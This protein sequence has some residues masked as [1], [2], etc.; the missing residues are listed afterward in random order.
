MKSIALFISLG[1][2]IAGSSTS[3]DELIIRGSSTVHNS[4]LKEG[5][6][7]V[8]QATSL[9]LNIVPNGSG[10]GI[11]DLAL[12]RADM[13][14][15]SSSLDSIAD[16]LNAK[17]P[18]LIDMTLYQ[19]FLIKEVEA[20]FVTHES[21]PVVSLTG[22]QIAGLLSGEIDNWKQVGG[23][24]RPVLV[25]AA[26]SGDGVRSA[27]ESLFLEPRQKAFS[28]TAREVPSANQV[29]NI[30][31]QIPHAIAAVGKATLRP[32]IRVVNTDARIAQPLSLVT[33]GAPNDAQMK[34]IAAA[35]DL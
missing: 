25:I 16:S 29:A 13:A 35:R 1:L 2:A 30:V 23:P 27:V 6:T 7:A 34:V 21:N 3:A 5:Q 28:S 33:K 22:D 12:G 8:E 4:L 11:T 24:D 31:A 26:I 9:S 20:L 32:G 10:A 15:I 19:T 18:G 14:M 17:R